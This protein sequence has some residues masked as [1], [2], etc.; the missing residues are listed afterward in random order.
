[1]SGYKTSIV[2]NNYLLITLFILTVLSCKKSGQD[3]ACIE[4]LIIPVTA[5]IVD[6]ADLPTI[7][8][9]FVINGVDNS[10]YRYYRYSQ[11]SVQTFFPP[12][13]K[14]DQK[15]VR[16]D[17]YTKG[18]RILNGQ[19]VFSFKNDILDMTVFNING[20]QFTTSTNLNTVPQL[21]L[22]TIRKLFLESAGKFENKLEEYSN[23]CLNA[24]FGYYNINAGTGNSTVVLIKAWKVTP[25]DRSFPSDYPQAVYRDDNG[26]L[27][28]YDNGI[29]TFH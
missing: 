12:F 22:G 26:A 24:E 9:L 20:G 8:R 3:D 15:I 23:T 29:R 6:N 14:F 4:R 2:K 18:L 28:Y 25:A 16:V 10:H 27:I 19:L 17:Q 13:A 7:N 21:N 1:M 11:D 5:H